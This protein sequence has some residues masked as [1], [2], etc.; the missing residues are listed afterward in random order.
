MPIEIVALIDKPWLL[1]ALLGLGA[2]CGIFVERINATYVKAKRRAY[3]E[4]RK[5]SAKSGWVGRK[6]ASFAPKEAVLRSAADQLHVVMG[7]TFNERP[8]LNKPEARLFRELD[9]LVIARNPAW[10]VMAQV[11]VGEFLSSPDPEAYGCINSK[12]VD[13]LLVDGDCRARHALEYQGTGHHQGCGGAGER[14]EGR[15]AKE[16]GVR[17]GF[18]GFRTCHR[19]PTVIPMGEFLS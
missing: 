18:R 14:G 2:A 19:N 3:W 9:K 4:K 8:L 12:R 15:E 10:Q 17:L 6:G 7:A 11:S 5:G 1:A 13:L 16:G